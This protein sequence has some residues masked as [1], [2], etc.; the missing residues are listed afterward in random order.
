[1]SRRS[2]V[3]AAG[4]CS[5]ARETIRRRLA[6]ARRG[7]AK[8]R[9]P[10]AS[11]A[12]RARGGDG[13]LPARHRGAARGAGCAGRLDR[14]GAEPVEEARGPCHLRGRSVR[15]ARGCHLAG[16]RPFA[17]IVHFGSRS[18]MP[19][20]CTLRSSGSCSDGNPVIRPFT[21]A[22]CGCRR[23]RL[24]SRFRGDSGTFVSHARAFSRY[25]GSGWWAGVPL[26]NIAISGDP[27]GRAPAAP[28]PDTPLARARRVAVPESADRPGRA[29]A[30]AC[31]RSQSA[32][33]GFRG[34]SGPCR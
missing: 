26:R 15:V 21:S 22:R 16:R 10:R 23:R 3:G 8:R 2:S 9:E 14:P 27:R 30:S 33:Q 7:R 18:S 13:S 20:R 24:L 29:W 12:A 28:R 6:P 1:M 31:A 4:Y 25:A 34:S 11:A 32:S 17:G 19:F 5:P